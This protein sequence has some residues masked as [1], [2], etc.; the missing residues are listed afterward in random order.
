VHLD[1]GIS[2]S[3]AADPDGSSEHGQ[4][5]HQEEEDRFRARLANA[6]AG[7]EVLFDEL[8][9]AGHV[10]TAPSE[11]AFRDDTQRGANGMVQMCEVEL[12]CKPALSEPA[13]AALAERVAKLLVEVPGP[14]EALAP[15]PEPA[16]VPGKPWWKVW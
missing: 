5:H 2:I 16:P 13:L 6:A 9:E 3:W 7:I 14:P 10:F 11:K 12:A 8:E 1:A 4:R 15:E